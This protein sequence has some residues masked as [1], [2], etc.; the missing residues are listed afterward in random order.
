MDKGKRLLRRCLPRDGAI[1][2]PLPN[3][4]LML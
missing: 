1:H 2:P 4:G 3:E